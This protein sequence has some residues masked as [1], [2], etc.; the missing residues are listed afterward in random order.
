[1]TIETKDLLKVFISE[2]TE[3]IRTIGDVEEYSR[4]ASEPKFYEL[5]TRNTIGGA[6]WALRAL[7]IQL[8]YAEG[9]AF[10]RAMDTFFDQHCKA[11]VEA[12]ETIGG[13]E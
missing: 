11:I 3:N 1:M 7:S 4:C 8:P 2:V 12:Y 6:Y 13:E 10:V 9:N 5:R